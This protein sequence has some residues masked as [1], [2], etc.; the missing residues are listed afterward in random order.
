MTEL[1]IG[2]MDENQPIGLA[3]KRQSRYFEAHGWNHVDPGFVAVITRDG[4]LDT[5]VWHCT[6]NHGTPWQAMD[7]AEAQ[8]EQGEQSNCDLCFTGDAA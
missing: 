2:W 6:H 8:R 7:C 4:Y 1:E 3:S 5:M